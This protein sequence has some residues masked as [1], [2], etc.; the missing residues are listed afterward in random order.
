[1]DYTGDHKDK[2]VC[3]ATGIVALL[4]ANPDRAFQLGKTAANTLSGQNYADVKLKRSDRVISI[5]AASDSVAIRGKE[6]EIDPMSLFLR[7]TCTINNPTDLKDHLAYE[8]SKYPPSMFLNGMMRKTAKNALANTLKRTVGL[9][10]ETFFQI[11]Y[12]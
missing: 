1:M 8:F 12:L 11:Q 3:I 6:V 4:L 9:S 2:L 7:V 10:V 5:G